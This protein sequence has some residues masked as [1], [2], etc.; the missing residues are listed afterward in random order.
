[1]SKPNK[2]LDRD[3]LSL[4]RLPINTQLILPLLVACLVAIPVGFLAFQLLIPRWEIWQ[5]LWETTLPRMLGNTLFLLVV[6]GIGT[7]TIG[8]GLAWL[9]TAYRFPARGLF[10]RALL[11]PLAIP[12]FV[13]GFVFMATFDFTGPVQTFLRDLFGRGFRINIRTGWGAAIVL[14]S[15]LYPYV[16]M[17]ARAAFREQAASTFEAARVMGYS[18]VRALFKLILPLARPSLIAGVTLALMETITDFATVRF[19]SFPTLSEGVVRLWEGRMDR[20]AAIEVATLLLFLALGLILLE[21]SLRGQARYYQAGGKGRRPE[22]VQLRGVSAWAAFVICL[23]V[24]G[25]AFV[26]PAGVLSVWTYREIVIGSEI[27]T[28]ETVYGQYIFNSFSFAGSAAIL[29]VLLAIGVAAGVRG[30][31]TRFARG[32]ARFATLGYALPGSV[33]AVAVLLVIAPIDHLLID[34]GVTS[35]LIL[36]GSMIGLLYA[37]VV[38]FM[39]VAYNSVEASLDKVRPNMEQAART[40]GAGSTRILWRVQ[41]PLVA[42]GIAVAMIL[43]FVDVMKELPATI[44]LRPFGMDTLAVWTYMLA[45]ESF[46]QAAALPAMTILVVGLL[47]V[48]ILMRVGEQSPE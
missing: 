1:M 6:V 13:M 48:L 19:F 38:R 10:D 12:S 32:L 3:R 22:R 25:F 20:D 11:L 43:V 7:F 36:T 33:I 14:I 44:L 47:P 42:N 29:T 37:Y 8:T 46:W 2:L 30:H 5:Q 4:I 23:L 15:V 21:R 41:I 45:A 28:W 17:L 26:L 31:G 9:V 18:R 40:M 27:G 35:S 16:Y 34:L 39:S 24:L